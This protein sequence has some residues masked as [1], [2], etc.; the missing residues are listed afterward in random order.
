MLPAG[1]PGSFSGLLWVLP[2]RFSGFAM[3]EHASAVFSRNSQ[4][5]AAQLHLGGPQVSQVPP[6]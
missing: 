6:A 4:H 5:P 2:S 3:L 1:L